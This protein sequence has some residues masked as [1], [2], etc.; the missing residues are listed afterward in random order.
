[1]RICKQRALQSVFLSTLILTTCGCSGKDYAIKV[2][3]VVTLD[4]NPL[5]GAT[6][7]FLPVGVGRSASGRTDQDGKFMLSTYQTDDGALAGSYKVIVVSTQSEEK[8]LGRDP[9][10]FTNQEKPKHTELF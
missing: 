9:S 3:G 6:V 10:T 8:L 1:M 5:A 7:S 2:E 4:G